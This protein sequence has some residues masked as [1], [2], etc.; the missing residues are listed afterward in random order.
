[1]RIIVTHSAQLHYHQVHDSICVNALCSDFVASV[2]SSIHRVGCPR[3]DVELGLT[4]EGEINRHLGGIA[5]GDGITK[6]QKE[7]SHCLLLRSKRLD[8]K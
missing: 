4:F 5:V 6:I 8:P 2:D 7:L 1:M 3:V